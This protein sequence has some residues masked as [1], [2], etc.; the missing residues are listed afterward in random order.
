M[1][2]ISSV[3]VGKIALFGKLWFERR[4]PEWSGQAVGLANVCNVVWGF[5][6]LLR[7]G[8]KKNKFP[9][10]CTVLSKKLNPPLF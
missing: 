10:I 2:Q 8:E 3:C 4:L 5:R 7:V 1:L 9:Q 6:L